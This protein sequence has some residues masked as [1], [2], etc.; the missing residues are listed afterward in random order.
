VTYDTARAFH[1]RVLGN[2]LRPIGGDQFN[3]T[4]FGVRGS[5]PC[6]GPDI[7]RHGGNTS[8]VAVDVPGHNSIMLDLG[9]G[10]RRY[11]LAQPDG[12]P[13]DGVCLLSHLHWD[14]VQGLPFFPPALRPGSHLAIHAPVQENGKPLK[15]A[16]RK[17]WRPPAFPVG[18]AELPAEFT[19]HEHG[20]DEFEIGD[21]QV[22]SRFVPHVGNTLGY[23]LEWRGRSVAYI[24]DHQQPPGPPFELPQGVRDLCNGVDVL[25]HDAQYTPE[26]F[27]QKADW[28]HSTV[29]F[30][31]WVAKECDAETLVL[32]HH[33][34][35]H[36][37]DMLD[38]LR[39]RAA[40]CLDGRMQV[41]SA[42]E[43][44]T[45]TIGR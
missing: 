6:D 14:H 10:S 39:D 40:A 30:A 9:T 17:L 32:F 3:V 22:M 45:L 43:S 35:A 28:G 16:F 7:E 20:D 42:A 18:I 41:I 2:Y 38:R 24:S 19:F 29:E 27:S 36:S 4:F 5:T 11:G 37:D 33:D 44:L 31:A 34:P 15:K 1:H 23:R 26:E 13:Y 12:E 8:C 25:I 21:V